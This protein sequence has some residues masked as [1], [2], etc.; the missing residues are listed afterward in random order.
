MPPNSGSGTQLSCTF[1]FD[2][3]PAPSVAGF[4]QATSERTATAHTNARR[5]MSSLTRALDPFQSGLAHGSCASTE[6]GFGGDST[7]RGLPSS[8]IMMTPFALD[9]VRTTLVLPVLS[10]TESEAPSPELRIA[11]ERPSLSRR[12]KRVLP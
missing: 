11:A 1:T 2:L 12:T 7:A 6:I 10:A 5:R 8:S 9:A 3:P 4:L